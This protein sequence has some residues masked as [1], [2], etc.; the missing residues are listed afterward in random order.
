VVSSASG[1]DSI[2]LVAFSQAVPGKV[3]AL[4]DSPIPST[5]T[6]ADHSYPL[7]LTVMV[8]SDDEAPDQR[9]SGLIKY[10]RSADVQSLVVH[11]GLVAKEGL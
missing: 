4:G 3:L 10:A 5:L 1:R 9:A 8:T 11:S 2:G 6:I 7:S